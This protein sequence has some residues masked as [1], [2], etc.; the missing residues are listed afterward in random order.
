MLTV[1]AMVS[2]SLLKWGSVEQK[3][4]WLPLLAKGEIIG[5]FA[6]SG[7]R[8]NDIT[9]LATE[10]TPSQGG[11]FVLNGAKKWITRAQFASLF[12]VFGN[13]GDRSLACLVPRG[14][15]AVSRWNPFMI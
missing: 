9:S 3:Q 15:F 8:R 13:L 6:L 2:M 11:V 12:L 5:A 10:F 1:Q 14:D 4:K 7:A